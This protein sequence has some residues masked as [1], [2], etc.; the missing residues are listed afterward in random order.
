MHFILYAGESRD[1]NKHCACWVIS[2]VCERDESGDEK[3]FVGMLRRNN[4]DC[5]SG[6]ESIAGRDGR[7][8]EYGVTF[9]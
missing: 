7:T 8:V 2:A 1:T 5:G 6:A 4:V 9:E 3:T